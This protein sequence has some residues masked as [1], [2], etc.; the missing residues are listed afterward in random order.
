MLAQKQ[1]I[2]LSLLARLYKT[3]PGQAKGRPS[4]LICEITKQ[5]WGVFHYKS[6]NN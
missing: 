4:W 6:M 3:H 5:I 2:K 1:Y